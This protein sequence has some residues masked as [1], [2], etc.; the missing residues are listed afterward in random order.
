M[1]IVGMGSQI[2][3]CGRI[4]KMIDRHGELFL[5]RVYTGNEITACRAS[6]RS[7]ERFAELWA[8]KAAIFTSIGVVWTK[9]VHGTDIEVTF[10]PL[11]EVQVK[12]VGDAREKMQARQVHEVLV[13]LAHCRAYATAHA[14]AVRYH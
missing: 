9:D 1:R 2:V 13:S 12:I 5:T 4:G 6:R 8:A 10:G 7:T 3:E 14:L 11:G